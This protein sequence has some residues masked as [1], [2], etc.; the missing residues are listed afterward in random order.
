MKEQAFP[1]P[2]TALEGFYNG[3]SCSQA[4][5][6]GIAPLI[7]LDRDTARKISAAF[8][9]GMRHQ[10]VCGCVTGAMMALGY[11]YGN[12]E[13]VQGSEKQILYDKI[14]EYEKRFTEIYGSVI[15]PEMLRGY[16]PSVWEDQLEIRK[17]GLKR[18][19]CA[20]AVCTA[21][22]L[23]KEIMELPENEDEG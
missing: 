13:E 18:T 9:A 3:I 20:E 23:L 4:V 8:G 17:Q 19:V 2:M 21:C 22:G 6:G 1:D 12:I 15:C 7:G 14:A 11:R 10:G 5:F 16:D